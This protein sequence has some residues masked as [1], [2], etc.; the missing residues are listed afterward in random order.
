[1]E[2]SS[3]DSALFASVLVVNR[4]YMAVHVVNVR[5]AFG[6]LYRDL[7][8]VLDVEAGQYANYD[9]ASWL[10]MSELRAEI[11]GEHDDWIRAVTFDVQVPRI[12]RLLKYDKVPKQSTR[13]NRKNLFAR[14]GNQCQYCGRILASGQLSIDHV[15][16][17]SRGGGTTWDNVVACCVRC[18]SRKGGRTPQEAHMKL[19]QQPRK[20]SNNPMFADKLRNPKYKTWRA[21]LG[22]GVGAEVA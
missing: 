12:I 2:S 14:D 3:A 7:A 16:P 8:E 5:R 22:R 10:E 4:F 13:F 1:M 20:P 15:V 17:R 6:L 21:F 19:L 9:F 11:K 18:N